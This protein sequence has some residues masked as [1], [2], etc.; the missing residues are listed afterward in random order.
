MRLLRPGDAVHAQQ[1]LD[2]AWLRWL[3]DVLLAGLSSVS[4]MISVS[5][6]AEPSERPASSIAAY[7]LGVILGG[8][9]LLRRRWPGAVLL[10]SFVA[11]SIYNLTD[12]PSIA[13]VWPLIIPLCTMAAAGRLLFA[14]VVALLALASSSVWLTYQN[15]TLT[16]SLIDGIFREVLLVIGALVLGDSLH[17]RS[18]WSGEVRRRLQR[19]ADQRL[20]DERLRIAHELHD[21]TAHTLAVVGIQIGVAHDLVARDLEKGREALRT[22]RDVNNEAIAELQAA[23]HVLRAGEEKP[24][25]LAPLPGV[26]DI[27][28]LVERAGLPRLKIELVE[29]GD[30]ARV[31]PAVG[32]AIYRIV[33]ESLTNVLKHSNATS[34]RV[35]L[36]YRNDGVGVTVTDNG[37]SAAPA[38]EP[39]TVKGGHGLA[40]MRERATSLG[41]RLTAGVGDDG[42]YTVTGWIPMP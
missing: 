10:G 13:P 3:I 23:V 15:V 38:R 20:T 35:E 30:P 33:Q 7:I 11:V 37:T 5:V 39:A 1:Q 12:F 26:A 36:E 9:L 42:H 4:V 34:A 14:T 29:E 21:V 16:L 28:T 19:E 27:A 22:A 32:L 8:L 18:R 2:T 31:R 24:P 17:S 40:G 41:G 6:S 25:E